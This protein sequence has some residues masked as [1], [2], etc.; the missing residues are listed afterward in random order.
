M[1]HPHVKIQGELGAL[2]THPSMFV[3]S[4]Q[5]PQMGSFANTTMGGSLCRNFFQH[6]MHF[7]SIIN[8]CYVDTAT[9][10]LVPWLKKTQFFCAFELPKHHMSM[11]LIQLLILIGHLYLS[12]M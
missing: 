2:I 5:Q 3:A 8:V 6:N 4:L 11:R 1:S 7:S 9:G 12:G 10:G